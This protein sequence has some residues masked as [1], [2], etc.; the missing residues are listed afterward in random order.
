MTAAQI[1]V[2]GNASPEQLAAVLAALAMRTRSQSVD[3]Y[4]SWRRR[5]VAALGYRVSVPR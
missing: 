2:R 1:N 5:R 3:A 4:A